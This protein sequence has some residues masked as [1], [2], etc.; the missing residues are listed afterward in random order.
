MIGSKVREV[1][2][3]TAS[4]HHGGQCVLRSPCTYLARDQ[5]KNKISPTVHLGQSDPTK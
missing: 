5:K 3:L 4:S 2:F 1:F